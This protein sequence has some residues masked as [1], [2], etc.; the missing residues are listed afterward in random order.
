VLKLEKDIKDY[1]NEDLDSIELEAYR[2]LEAI[3]ERANQA[4]NNIIAVRQERARREK[5]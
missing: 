1:K 2:T 5:K 3:Q 4:R